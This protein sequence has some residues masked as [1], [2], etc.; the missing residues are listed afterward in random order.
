[1]NRCLQVAHLL[2]RQLP[3]RALS[4]T[5]PAA[6]RFLLPDSQRRTLLQNPSGSRCGGDSAHVVVAPVATTNPS[7]TTAPRHQRLASSATTRTPPADDGLASGPGKHLATILAGTAAT[8]PDLLASRSGG[9]GHHYPHGGPH[10]LHL[11][12]QQ[13]GDLQRL[14]LE[15]LCRRADGAQRA[16][17]FASGAAAF[18][19]M[20]TLM[21]PGDTVLASAHIRESA[22]R[23]LSYAAQRQG[24]RV[25]YVRTWR[26]AEVER[27]LERDSSVRHIYLD[28][29][30]DPL[31]RVSDVR[32]IVR[33]AR[34]RQ[35][36][37]VVDNSAMTPVL[38][39][40]IELGADAVVYS[41]SQLLAGHSNARAGL[42]AVADADLAARIAV[43][44]S[45][46]GTT[47]S[48]VDSQVVLQGLRTLSLRVSAAQRNA[49]LL[50]RFL[51][52]HPDIHKVHYLDRDPT[53]A[54]SGSTS[55]TSTSTSST[56]SSTSTGSTSASRV[57][58][59]LHFSQA[60][61]GGSLLCFETG[62]AAFSRDV[63]SETTLFHTGPRPLG[64]ASSLIDT[65]P[66]ADMGH[67]LTE[68]GPEDIV[69]PVGG[70]V[71]MVA[72]WVGLL[73]LVVVALGGCWWRLL[74]VGGAESLEWLPGRVGVKW[75]GWWRGYRCGCG[76]GVRDGAKWLSR[77]HFPF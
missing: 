32:G 23:I 44:R 1:M 3:Q 31:L 8:L 26:L 41:G 61:G 24:I 37:V 30:S 56:R 33:A 15:E 47:L 38:M 59:S 35:V 18:H 64:Y 22:R 60:R 29:P 48:E 66:P 70:W 49:E 50:A 72:A 42:V 21:R 55:S 52:T 68:L 13:Q 69:P 63:L 34:R 58:H 39:S 19:A 5:S 77:C 51:A 12:L 40:P 45:T 4:G 36:L 9:G 73:L 54:D 53:F 2:G 17:A 25:R 57:E 6:R 7:A 28:S 74:A 20:L 16:F 14:A 46:L 27:A 10:L 75:V 67:L 71:M 11:Q 43:A 76:C 65:P 62:S